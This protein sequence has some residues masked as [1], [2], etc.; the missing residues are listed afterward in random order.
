[1]LAKRRGFFA[2]VTVLSAVA[3]GFLAGMAFSERPAGAE[4]LARPVLSKG[5]LASGQTIMGEDVRYPEGSP[6]RVSAVILTLEPGQ[7]TGWHTH[8]VPTFGYVLDGEV[9]VDYRGR[10]TKVYRAGEAVLEAMAIPHNGRNA[11]T[12]PMRI[13][14]VF[15]GAD[16]VTTSEKA[17]E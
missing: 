6:A 4:D 9:T 1:M 5:L 8:G 7:E 12:V 11:G 14:A 16:G 10:E 17:G 2:I 15:M 13:L 3:L